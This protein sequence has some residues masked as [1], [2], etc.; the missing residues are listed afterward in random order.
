MKTRSALKLRDELASGERSSREVTEHYLRRIDEL[1]SLGAFVYVSPDAMDAAAAADEKQVRG[2]IGRLHG[3]PSAFKDLNEVAGMPTTYG[4]AA[5]EH[6]LATADHPLVARLRSE[7]VVITGKTQVPEFGLSS[8]SENLVAP[9]SRNPLDPRLTSGG[10]SGGQAAAI[11]AGMI[12]VG[13]GSDGGGSVRI[14]AAACGLVGLKPSLGRVPSDVADGYLDAF[15][16]PKM[17]VSGPLAHDALDAAMLLDAMRGSDHFLPLLR[18]SYPERLKGLRIGY[19]T[20]SPFESAYPITLQAP[21]REAFERAKRLLEARHRVEPADL[22]Y[23]GDY[24]ET[25][26]RVWTNGLRNIPVDDESLLG[27]LARD[28]R[29]RS[30]ARSLEVSLQAASRLKQIAADFVRQWSAHDV[31]LTPAMA[32]TPPEIGYFTRKDADTDYM[33]QC[34]YTPYTSMVN[35][36][37]V[38]AI[39]VPITNSSSGMPMSVQLIS[40]RADEGLLLALAKQLGK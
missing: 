13:P 14:P 27:E 33:L 34:Q 19:S 25:F 9:P 22:H 2:Q 11:A 4:S 32:S 39:T 37:S 31:I 15:G 38:A 7:G 28:F 6:Q 36:S 12:P 1:D 18:G 30:T 5:M 23:A 24:P 40:P 21:A 35:V 29:R 16:A 20:L 3:L 10:S 8:Y 17:T 26:A